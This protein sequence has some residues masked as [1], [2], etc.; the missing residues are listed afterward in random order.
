MPDENPTPDEGRALWM[1]QRAIVTQLLRDDHPEC[2]TRPELEAEITD[3][4]PQSLLAALVYLA[5]EEVLRV[6]DGG[7]QASKCARHLDSLE[8]VSI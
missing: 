6:D 7:V 1:A 4:S 3:I 8:L 2:W 5:I